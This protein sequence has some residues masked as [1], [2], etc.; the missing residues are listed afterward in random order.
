MVTEFNFEGNNVKYK[1]V[2]K[3]I[4]PSSEAMTH[5]SVYESNPK[6]NA[7]IHVHHKGLWSKALREGIPSTVPGVEFGTPEMALEI[8]MLFNEGKRMECGLIVMA[9]HEDGLISFGRNMD[10][11]GEIMMKYYNSL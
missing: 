1:G 2:S 7:V 10:E 6:A 5:A 3:E 11:A 4:K 9:G 8:R